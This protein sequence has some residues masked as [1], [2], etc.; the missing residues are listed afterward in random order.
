MKND[1]RYEIRFSGSGGQG[2]I[3]AAVVMADAVAREAGKHVCQ[4]Q[5]YGPEARGGKSKA[6][7]VV[8]DSPIDYP[9]ALSI[10]LLLAM[11][12]VACDAYFFDI[13]P[14]GLLVVDSDLVDQVPTSRA[15]TIPFTRI[16]RELTGKELV[17]NMVAL[18]AVGLLSGQVSMTGLEAALMKRVPKGTEEMNRQALQAGIVEAKKID[19]SLLPRSVISDWADD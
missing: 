13:R 12:Q 4:T 14:E 11:T 7:V 18:G 10:D 19:L 3:T 6:E 16:A 15:V 9:K 5:S 17:A 2:I 8:S 1:Q